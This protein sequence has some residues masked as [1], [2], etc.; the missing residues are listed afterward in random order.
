M[1]RRRRNEAMPR[2]RYG[3]A[4]ILDFFD[5]LHLELLTASPLTQSERAR[6]QEAAARLRALQAKYGPLLAPSADGLA[7]APWL[8]WAPAE[9][10]FLEELI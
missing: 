1:P 3:R 2:A 9:S 5:Q 6:H 10:A 8:D 7:D 4:M